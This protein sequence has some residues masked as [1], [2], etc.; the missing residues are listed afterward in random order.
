M[1]INPNNFQTRVS[2]T[3]SLANFARLRS[4]S[5]TPK[6]K[7]KRP[8]KN[9]GHDLNM[10]TRVVNASPRSMWSYCSQ[11]S[12]LM[13]GA[14]GRLGSTLGTGTRWLGSPAVNFATCLNCHHH[15]CCFQQ[16]DLWHQP[17][18]PPLVVTH[19]PAWRHT[20]AVTLSRAKPLLPIT[21]ARAQAARLMAK[22]NEEVATPA[23][24]HG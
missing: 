23:V 21:P 22:D 19:P 5:A 2:A 20:R 4:L 24:T 16:S 17:W 13:L 15:V 3:G 10:G 12:T 11:L 9:L 14:T 8:L 6:L 1:G 7:R 18:P